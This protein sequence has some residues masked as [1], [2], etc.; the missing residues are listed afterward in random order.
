MRICDTNLNF[1]SGLPTLFDFIFTGTSGLLFLSLSIWQILISYFIPGIQDLFLIIFSFFGRISSQTKKRSRSNRFIPLYVRTISLHVEVFGF[2]IV[3]IRQ[4]CPPVFNF[5]HQFS[6]LNF[7]VLISNK[8]QTDSD[9]TAPW[10][11]SSRVKNRSHFSM[12][13][14]ITFTITF[15]FFDNLPRFCG[16]VIESFVY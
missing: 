6:Q 4:C 5:V 8:I 10:A 9:R 13:D 16:I 11:S 7:S 14:K 1:D 12:V 2:E 3:S 15:E